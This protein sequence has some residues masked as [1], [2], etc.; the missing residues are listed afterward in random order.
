MK[1]DPLGHPRHPLVIYL[2][3]LALVTGVTSLAG[4]GTAG[5]VEA[6]LDRVAVIGWSAALAAG[7]A[8]VLLGMFWQ[9]DPRTGLVLK[10]WGYYALTLAAL[11]YA[12]VLVERFGPAGA[13]P[14]AA[15]IAGFA[16]ACGVMARRIRRVIKA[17]VAAP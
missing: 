8:T 6:E 9:G 10:G 7:S 11:V 12:L 16:V 1:P 13:M 15:T 4:T 3:T 17:A 14:V 2:L 5:S